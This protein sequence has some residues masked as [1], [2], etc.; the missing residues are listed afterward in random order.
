MTVKREHW[1]SEKESIKT[2]NII[3][4]TKMIGINTEVSI[5]PLS[6]NGRTVL[7]KQRIETISKNKNKKIQFKNGLQT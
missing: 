6:F 2:R 4:S 5:I 3:K 1:V 7:L